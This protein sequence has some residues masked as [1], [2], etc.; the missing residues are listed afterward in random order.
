[1]RGSLRQ[2]L[3]VASLLGLAPLG[4][5]QPAPFDLAGP[6]LQ[7]TVT[8]GDRTL[9]IAEVPN[10]AAG[11]RVVIKTELP[12]TQSAHYLLIAAFLNGSTNPPPSNQFSSS[13]A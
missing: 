2:T 12:A 6:N 10:L 7:V 9:P 11:D 4:F 5:A 3:V 1:M 13:R 8:R